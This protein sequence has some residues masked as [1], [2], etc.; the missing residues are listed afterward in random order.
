M[1]ND[2]IVIRPLT[3]LPEMAAVE[4]LQRHI[5]DIPDMEIVPVHTQIAIQSNGGALIGAFDGEQLVG[6]AL[7]LL[8]A[9]Q[10]PATNHLM[11][12]SVV[13][14]ALPAYQGQGIGYQL[15]LAQREAALDLGLDLMMWTYDPLESVNGRFNIHKLGAICQMYR[16]DYYG[17]L[18]GINAGLPTD[19]FKVAWHLNSDQVKACVAGTRRP[20][21]LPNLLAQGATLLNK[22][23][24]SSDHLP[25]PPSQP[26]APSSRVVLVEIPANIQAVKQKNAALALRW[27]E[28]TR[29][30]FEE[31]FQN[32]YVVTDFVRHQEGNGRWRS[33]YLLEKPICSK[34][35]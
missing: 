33:F 20:S 28:H 13:A 29:Q 9:A 26:Q 7:G 18:K 8:G 16:R 4:Q 32:A 22:T 14:G 11:M 30:L 17:Q 34:F 1:M 12:Y 25:I 24:F 21:S 19:R 35:S 10:K 5:W 6:F 3:T 15:K 2:E 27:R 23:H 31:S